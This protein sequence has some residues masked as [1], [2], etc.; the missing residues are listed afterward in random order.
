MFSLDTFNNWDSYYVVWSRLIR[1][2]KFKGQIGAIANLLGQDRQ[3]KNP[4]NPLV[5]V[6]KIPTIFINGIQSIKQSS[7]TSVGVARSRH[8]ACSMR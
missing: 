1:V 5:K 2:Q 7:I 6:A 8:R 4:L 3:D